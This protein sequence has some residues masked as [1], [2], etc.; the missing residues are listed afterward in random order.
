MPLFKKFSVSYQNEALLHLQKTID[1]YNSKQNGLGKR[2]GS[3][4]IKTSKKLEKNPYFQIRYDNIR[5]VPIKKFPFMIHFLVQEEL[6][7]VRI[8]AILH[9]SLDPDQFWVNS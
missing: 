6:K 2:F 7:K 4:V 8:Y 1:Y 3:E 5:C 9:T